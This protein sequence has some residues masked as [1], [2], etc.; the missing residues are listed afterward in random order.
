MQCATCGT[1]NRADRR[2]CSQCG[3]ALSLTCPS[4]GT[5]NEPSDRFCGSCGSALGDGA[6]A[7]A[8][9]AVAAERRLVSVLFADL[10]GF[11][12]LAERRDP[13]EVRD[14]LSRYFDRCRTLIEQHGGVVEKFIGDAV[15]A[16]WGTPVAREDDAERSV[17][18][19][20][21]LT[22][23]VTALGEQVGMP[24]LRVRA[25][26]LTG[27]AAVDLAAERE[28]MVLGDTVNTAS[29]LQSI[30]APGTVLVDDVTRRTTEAAI[31]YEDA[32]THEVKGREQPV[33][34]WTALRVVAGVGGARRGPGLE[35]PFV[36]RD[37][38]LRHVISAWE[39]SVARRATRLVTVVGDAGSGKS[40]L[41]WEY[42]KHIDGLEQEF[43]WHQGRC[44]SYGEGVGYWALTE[45]VRSRAGI[46]EDEDA[47]SSRA[48]LRDAVARYVPDERERRLV[49]PRL[50]HLLGLEQRVAPDRA[51]L[52]S[53]WRL[54]F[55]RVAATGPV[56]MVFEDVQWADG[57][58]LDFVD[59]LIEWSAELPI[60]VLALA[61]PEIA[62][63][64][65]AWRADITLTPL[66][67]DA[68][69]AALESLV[70]GLP[71][72][73][74]RRILARAEGVP[75]YAIE[76]IRMLLD[77]GL[78]AQEGA[79]YVLTG[80]VGDLD[81]PETLHALVAAR[82]DGLDPVERT[83]LQLGSVLGQSFSPAG[84]AAL[85]GRPI[86]DVRALLDSLVTKQVLAF[87]DDERSPERGQ[88]RFL[89]GL[90]Q[91]IAYGTLSRRD[92]KASHL[93]AARHLQE[94]AGDALGDVADVLASHF[95]AAAKADPE[96]PDAP[97]IRASARETLAE[98][99]RR[100]LSLAL[101]REAQH[102][103]DQAA[104]LADDDEDRA[105]LLEQA[106]RAAW[107]EADPDGARER[108]EA[109]IA[110]HAA[111]GR[112]QA[113]ARASGVIV[114]IL[115]QSD[116]LA[117]A[118]EVAERAFADLTEDNADRAAMAALLGKLR[119]FRTQAVGTLEATQQALEIAEPLELWDTVADA[120]ITRGAMLVWMDRP[121][122]GH[123]LLR[124]GTELAVAHDLPTA[125]LRGYNN[126]AWISELRDRLSEAEEY[127]AQCVELARSRGDR[128]W[129]RA[130]LASQASVHGQRG[131]WDDTERMAATKPE[132]AL[133][134][135]LIWQSDL[136]APLATIR[137][138]RGDLEG[139]EVLQQQALAGV[140][141]ADDQVREICLIAEA[142]A[143][144]GRGAHAEAVDVLV[145][146]ARGTLAV[147]RHYAIL[148]A[149]ESA[150]ALGREDLIEDTIAMVRA[151]PPAAA[152]PTIRAHADRFDALLA[153]RRGDIDRADR[154]L[155]AAAV[156]LA[157]VVRP[158][159]RAKVLLDHGEL[160]AGALRASEAEPLLREAADV[161]AGL[162]AE[163]W[164][165]R[166]E[167]TLEGEGAA[168]R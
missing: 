138:A 112:P 155:T 134:E 11:T 127:L 16:V 37:A 15:M 5:A 105:I 7:R 100:S 104:E 139:L 108:L 67:D 103:F 147:Y 106:G 30:A 45:M 27:S 149:L 121:E 99:G 118:I 10:V 146:L 150:F 163:P 95:L 114:D 49:E 71:D 75:L 69:R 59:Y 17:R 26:V 3:N 24:G 140:R 157:G 61:R 40:R 50:A 165:L 68:I 110:L 161:F 21:A 65:P 132:D 128:V 47:A 88:Y 111:G 35:A 117:Q 80:D 42:F 48:K 82:L 55:E 159:E 152:T 29:R 141:S 167:R 57:G 122:E 2:F 54:F 148:G 120:L 125:A 36:G 92:R 62:A 72:E 133:T 1:E 56:I 131:R 9:T 4:C 101:G 151:L 77:R 91:T 41:L 143:L 31:A 86:D 60:F 83:T 52:F 156:L 34:T 160:L 38:E 25:G 6:P 116:N 85:S 28:G 124:H 119:S 135:S 46:A 144:A 39:E 87:E 115:W 93:A 8:A 162:R 43:R 145:P 153:G 18:A 90:V 102:A 70:P 63:A 12:T 96:A 97:K 22:Q 58:L 78:L 51:D 158:F 142:L 164:R 166:A 19:A 113:A 136:L 126:L 13:E 84:V 89:Q 129:L 74:A 33:R 53:G 107:H 94:T 79:R 123:A 109:A 14:I 20:L 23:A 44:L 154:L 66:P 98:A 64:R 76:T 137:A 32:G 73:V 81:V 130:A 168:A